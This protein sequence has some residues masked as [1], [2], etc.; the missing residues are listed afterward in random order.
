MLYTIMQC[1]L[2]HDTAFYLDQS[3]IEYDTLNN[4]QEKFE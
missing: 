1:R 3:V 2:R 4:S